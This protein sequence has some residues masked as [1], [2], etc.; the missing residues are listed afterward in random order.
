MSIPLPPFNSN[1][2]NVLKTETLYQGFFKAEKMT[3]RHRL[4]EGGWSTD[5]VREVFVRGQ[6]VG[7]VLFDPVRDLIGLVEQIRIGAIGH[8]ASPWCLE[9][10]AGMTEIGESLTEVARREI[11]EETS[12]VPTAMEYICEY[13]ASPGGCTERLH[14]FCGLVDLDQEAGVH[15]LEEEGEDIK[16]YILPAQEVFDELY[17]GRFNNAATL[18]GLQWLQL[19]RARI[20]SEINTDNEL[21]EDEV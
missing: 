2:V 15:G 21:G 8:Q 14:L 11:E 12:L 5:I 4:Y 19:N 10:V 3:L 1:D 17:G 16:L 7:I 18:I 6:A 13:M 9:V 20:S